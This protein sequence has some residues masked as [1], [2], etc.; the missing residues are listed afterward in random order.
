MVAA[1]GWIRLD[2]DGQ[3]PRPGAMVWAAVLVPGTGVGPV[4]VVA[5]VAR[6]RRGPVWRESRS[7]R[8]IERGAAQVTHWRPLDVPTPPPA[9]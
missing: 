2:D 4:P 5:R 6:G 8:R 3:I 9:D 1:D 7:G